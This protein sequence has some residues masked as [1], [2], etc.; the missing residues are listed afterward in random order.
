MKFPR[1]WQPNWYATLVYILSGDRVLLIEK[2]RGHGSGKI[3]VP[4]GKVEDE[5]PEQGAIRETKEEVGLVVANLQLR[6][7]IRFF[8]RKTDYRVV[9]FVYTTRTFS[10]TPISTPEANPF[11]CTRKKIPFDKMWEDDLL[12]LPPV[13]AG[14][15]VHAD[16]LFEND[17]LVHHDLEINEFGFTESNRLMTLQ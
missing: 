7:V 9:G 8:D 16:L 4:G 12:W 15:Y 5:S 14:Q 1:T 6:A 3:N 17:V 10:G 13:L 2:L 11:W